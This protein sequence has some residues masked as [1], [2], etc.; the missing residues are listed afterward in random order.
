MP[1][2]QITNTLD[3][4]IIPCARFTCTFFDAS[5][6]LTLAL[7]FHLLSASRVFD[8]GFEKGKAEVNNCVIDWKFLG[9]GE[10][11]VQQGVDNLCAGDGGHHFERSLLFDS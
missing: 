9:I 6:F 10:I 4:R 5:L 1:S 8:L 7:R 11:S 3:I 2:M